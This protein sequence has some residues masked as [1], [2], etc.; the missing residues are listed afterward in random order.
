MAKAPLAAQQALPWREHISAT[1]A[2]GL[3]LIGTQLAQ[4]AIGTTDT[5]MIG[6]LGTRELAASVLGAQAYFVILMLGSG[7]A[8]ALMP[9][10][11]QA[12]GA[13]DV[14]AVRRTTRM[15][16]WISLAY[17]LA[18]MLPLWFLEP[19]LVALGQDPGIS[20][21]AGQYMR[22]MQWSI[23]PAMC[24]FAMR[25]FLAALEHTRIVLVATILA[26]IANGFLNYALIFG[27]WGAPAMGL[28]GAAVASVISSFGSFALLWLYAMRAPAIRRFELHV[29][30]WRPDWP[31]FR[32]VIHLGWP[33]SLTVIAEVAL[34]SASSLLMGWIGPVQLAAHGIALQLAS[35]A[36][37]VPLGF[38]SAGTIRVGKALGAGELPDVRR[39]GVTTLGLATCATATSAAL[40]LLMPGPLVWLFLDAAKPDAA[41]VAAFAATLLALAASFQLFDGTQAVSAGLLRGLKDMR[42][43][44][45]IA[46][47]S[48]WAIGMV[49]AY[50]LAFPVGLGGVGIW[51]GL[52]GGLAFAAV[53]LTARFFANLPR[54]AWR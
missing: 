29:R 11:A 27:H 40:F 35:L 32:E 52:A 10:I 21:M 51:L 31:A 12:V 38:A 22:I 5:V 6:W 49:L 25:S 34:F 28:R 7:F 9:M 17:C 42:V 13:G 19:I 14:R 48:Y 46:V 53:L 54:L 45:L 33:I 36:F 4:I 3:P 2:L 43:P 20:A 44:M 47:F 16:L 50:V 39:A 24:V 37:M 1:L 18:V 41:E 26:A 8:F 23:F 30:F 15:G